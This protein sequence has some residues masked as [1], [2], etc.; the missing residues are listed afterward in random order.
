MIRPK[1][2]RWFEMLTA[3]DDATLA[4]E[5][6][7]ATGKVELE[8]RV[9]RCALRPHAEL[10]PLLA[11]FA[12]LAARY[13]AYWPPAYAQ[14]CSPFPEP[15]VTALERS[16]ASIRAWAQ[17]AEP[18]IQ[19]VQRI[20]VER[21]ELVIWRRVLTALDHG[22]LQFTPI[23]DADGVVHKRLFVFPGDAHPALPQGVI[24]RPVNHDGVLCA[25]VVGTDEA[26]QSLEQQAAALKGR[27]HA[28]PAWLETGVVQGL[29]YIPARLHELERDE[30]AL[31]AAL[32][33]LHE[34]HDLQR[35]LGDARRLQWVAQNVRTLETTALF[36]WVTGW[37]SDL[38]GRQVAA[39]LEASG[40]RALLH[41]P[42]PPPDAQPPLLLANPWWARPFEIFCRALGMPSRNEA[43]PSVLLAVAVPLM[44]GYMFGDVGQGLVLA[45]AGFAL[46]N[47]FPIARLL[48]AGGVAAAMFGLLFGSVFSVH[49]IAPLWIAPLHDPLT[50]LLVPLAAGAVLLVLGLALNAVEAG[51][52]GEF[53]KWLSVDLGFVM[54]YIG[55]LGAALDVRALLAAAA[56][57]ALFCIGSAVH[58][59]KPMA[60]LTGLAELAERLVQLLLNTLSFARV[61][62]F[63]LAHAGLS[64]AIV[65]LMDASDN[66]TAKLAILIM[67]NVVILVLETL[68][69]AIQTTRLVLFEF[70]TRFLSATGRVFRPLPL[71]PSIPVHT[72]QET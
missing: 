54:T 55:L 3:R 21:D 39:A 31:D 17:Q 59:R 66:V 28:A 49:A 20:A 9:T 63:A 72:P 56:G 69:V 25:L 15:P 41:F 44:F 12:E 60:A 33:A 64:S 70:F 50:V 52:R 29:Q 37:T 18:M 67:G 4:L 30:A 38:D 57:A 13:Q 68:V 62:A 16:L 1:P 65:A 10:Q 22:P 11:Q 32:Q 71:P 6:L 43:D 14:R 47:R 24:A 46:R 58:E 2:A 61:G 19:R 26:M 23:G 36:C 34:R 42:T 40:A 5:A 7:A 48:V 53:D 51:W 45:V 35:A 27:F 8:P